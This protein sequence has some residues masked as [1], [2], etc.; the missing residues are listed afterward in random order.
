MYVYIII[1]FP[2]VE[3]PNNPSTTQPPRT[4]RSKSSAAFSR[5]LAAFTWIIPFP[6]SCRKSRG[7][8]AEHVCFLRNY[9]SR[10]F[11]THE[12]P[13]NIELISAHDHFTSWVCLK[14]RYTPKIAI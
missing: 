10:Y 3:P 4:A 8:S 12:M 9:F 1:F 11:S 2:L 6:T 14:M 7:T 13:L 5:S